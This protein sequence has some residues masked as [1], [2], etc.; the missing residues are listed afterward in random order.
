MKDPYPQVS[1][2]LKAH[3]LAIT[4][5]RY[6]TTPSVIQR[7]RLEDFLAVIAVFLEFETAKM[8]RRNGEELS[9]PFIEE[10][11][12]PPVLANRLITRWKHDHS[13]Q[14]RFPQFVDYVDMVETMLEG[15]RPM[16][17]ALLP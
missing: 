12:A 5:G 14:E 2:E 7:L 9:S 16:E 13:L 4:I 11:A 17:S 3:A 1:D 10:E 6:F 8:V 15:R